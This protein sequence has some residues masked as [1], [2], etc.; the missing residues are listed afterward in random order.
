MI[1][2]FILLVSVGYGA[3]ISGLGCTI[4]PTFVK[5]FFALLALLLLEYIHPPPFYFLLT[6]GSVFVHTHFASS[7]ELM[8]GGHD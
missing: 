2:A 3:L 6:F 4:P 7:D 1:V 8:T 5:A